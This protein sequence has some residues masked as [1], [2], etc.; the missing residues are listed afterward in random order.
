[1]QANKTIK[2]TNELCAEFIT[3]SRDYAR[4]SNAD[5]APTLVLKRE[6][7]EN[8]ELPRSGNQERTLHSNAL[9]FTGWEA[10]ASRKP[11]ILRA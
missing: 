4:L 7:G 9:A 1:M 10:G 3:M 11:V 8:P 2:N 5:G 6:S